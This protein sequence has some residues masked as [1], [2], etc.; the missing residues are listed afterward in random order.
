MRHKIVKKDSLYSCPFVWSGRRNHSPMLTLP[1]LSFGIQSTVTAHYYFFSSSGL[2][3]CLKLAPPACYHTRKRTAFPTVL[4][5]WSGRRDS[6][7]RLSPWQ[8]DTLPLS[9]SR[10]RDIIYQTTR[11]NA[12]VFAMKFAK[13]R[14]G[15]QMLYISAACDIIMWRS[16]GEIGRRVGFRFR[17][18][19][20][21]VQVPS[22][23]PKEIERS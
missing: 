17:W 7:P 13:I 6:D 14:R 4:L 12:T 3:R 11:Q 1:V 20:V 21:G 22:T 16:R 15:G 8:G 19:T 18:E 5:V 2:R 9:H 10:E 23:R